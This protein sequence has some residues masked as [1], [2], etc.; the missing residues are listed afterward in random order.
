MQ[1]HEQ[2]V[3]LGYRN[4]TQQ[5]SEFYSCNS[6][7][8][9]HMGMPNFHR[10]PAPVKDTPITELKTRE[11]CRVIYPL[12]NCGSKQIIIAMDPSEEFMPVVTIGKTGWSGYRLGSEALDVLTQ[13]LDYIND[14]FTQSSEFYAPL[15]LSA[16]DSV[17]FRKSWGKHMIC[18]TNKL[19]SQSKVCLAQSTWGGFLEVLPLLHQVNQM[20]KSWQSE[21]SAVFVAICKYMKTCLPPATLEQLPIVEEPTKFRAILKS[22]A[23][24]NITYEGNTNTMLDLQKCFLEIRTF[25]QEHIASYIPYV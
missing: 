19:D 6:K 15:H 24:E 20:Y 13:N 12:N 9:N 23:F 5:M 8:Y 11:I 17:E 2:L 21:A 7:V 25:C 3:Y 22:I 18:F 14:F 10:R 16:V 4:M 1:R